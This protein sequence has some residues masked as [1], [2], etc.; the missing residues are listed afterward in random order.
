MRSIYAVSCSDWLDERYDRGSRPDPGGQANLNVTGTSI[1]FPLP[2]LPSPL[3]ER[4]HSAIA[5]DLFPG[6]SRFL[7]AGGYILA[8]EY[9]CPEKGAKL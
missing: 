3:T 8:K 9:P 7:D 5:P 4:C 1:S 2:G 6:V